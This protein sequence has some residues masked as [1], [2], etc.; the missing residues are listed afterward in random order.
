MNV[1]DD[2]VGA[3]NTHLSVA[4]RRGAWCRWTCEV[5]GGSVPKEE[6]KEPCRSNHGGGV[7]CDPRRW[8]RGGGVGNITNVR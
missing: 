7:T 8:T 4:A 6:S 1:V 5:G 3:S 2:E